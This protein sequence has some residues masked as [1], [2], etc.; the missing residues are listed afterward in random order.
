MISSIPT[1]F[2]NVPKKETPEFHFEGIR[3]QTA[4]YASYVQKR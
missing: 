1:R 3:K 4:R 2:L